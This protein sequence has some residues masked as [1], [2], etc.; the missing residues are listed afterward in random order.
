MPGIIEPAKAYDEIKGRLFTEE[1]IKELIRC[2]LVEYGLI[3][4]AAEDE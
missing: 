4:G 3:D 2:A 1:E